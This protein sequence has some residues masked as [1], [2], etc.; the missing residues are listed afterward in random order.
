MREAFQKLNRMAYEANRS[1][2][3]DEG[4]LTLSGG[5]LECC[6]IR[7]WFRINRAILSGRLAQLVRAPALQ[8]ATSLLLFSLSPL[9]SIALHPFRDFAEAA[10]LN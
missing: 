10:W 7:K 5:V 8:G 3:M 1:F 4:Y 2:V 6:T 9:F